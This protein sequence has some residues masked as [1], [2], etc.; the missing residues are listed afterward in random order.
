VDFSF[1][2]DH[3]GLAIPKNNPVDESAIDAARRH[4]QHPRRDVADVPQIQPRVPGRRGRDHPTPHGVEGADGYHVAEVVK[5]EGATDGDG[6]HV[7]AVGDGVVEPREDVGLAAANLVDGEPGAGHPAASCAAGQ[8][9]HAHVAHR[10]PGRGG[11]R[12][13]AVAVIVQWRLARAAGSSVVG[14][15]SDDFTACKQCKNEF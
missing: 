3:D 13:A 6:D 1:S 2:A 10:A 15:C 8:A 7:H 14:A 5:R 11:C 9:V 4:R 12:V